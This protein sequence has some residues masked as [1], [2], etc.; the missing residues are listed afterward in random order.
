MAD[1]DRIHLLKAIGKALETYKIPDLERSEK[2]KKYAFSNIKISKMTFPLLI[3]TTSGWKTERLDLSVEGDISLESI[4]NGATSVKNGKFVL[5]LGNVLLQRDSEKDND[6]EYSCEIG[7]IEMGI[8][9]DNSAFLRPLVTVYNTHI[10]K[11]L[12]DV[13]VPRVLCSI[14]NESLDVEK[15]LADILVIKKK[16]PEKEMNIDENRVSPNTQSDTCGLESNPVTTDGNVDITCG[17]TEGHT[18]TSESE[19]ILNAL[20]V[21][22]SYI[23]S[24]VLAVLHR[25][26]A[27]GRRHATAS[28][29]LGKKVDRHGADSGSTVKQDT[30]I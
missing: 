9:G 15:I 17:K 4:T 29:E 1:T 3:K 6:K 18:E 25:G 23:C 21:L 10:A 26:N 22:G 7:F 30:E 27:F 5:S 8:T 28:D 20:K 13:V 19:G 24:V 11:F 12:E 2:D 14:Q 16:A